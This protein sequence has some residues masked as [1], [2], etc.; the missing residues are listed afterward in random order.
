MN[1]PEQPDDDTLARDH[2]GNL[3]PFGVERASDPGNGEHG[4]GL[5]ESIDITDVLDRQ[6]QAGQ[7]RDGQRI[8]V[9]LRPLTLVL[10]PGGATA[11]DV[12]RTDQGDLPVSIGRIGVY[13]T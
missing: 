4:H 10:P 12:S 11:S 2:V 9:T 5:R 6:A 8:T 1:L 3:A 7:W 13:Y